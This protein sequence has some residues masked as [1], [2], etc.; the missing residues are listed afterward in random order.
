MPFVPGE[1]CGSSQV[2]SQW[3][4]SAAG[5]A[6]TIFLL[7]S[8]CSKGRGDSKS[9]QHSLERMRMVLLLDS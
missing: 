8:F 1:T 3:Q 5:L 2:T 6:G 7:P 4:G 9:S